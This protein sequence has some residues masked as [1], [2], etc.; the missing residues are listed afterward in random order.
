MQRPKGQKIT[1]YSKRRS[2]R[3][4]SSRCDCKYRTRPGSM[5]YKLIVSMFTIVPEQC[6]YVV[7]RLGKFRKVL[8]PGF[9]W[10]VPL[11]DRVAY[12]HVLK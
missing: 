10:L 9:N 1:S 3:K 6:A 7:E 8:K 5:H 2:S 4:S 12:R 11:L